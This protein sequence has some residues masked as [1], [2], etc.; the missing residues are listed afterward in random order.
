MDGPEC[1]SF[2]PS[3]TGSKTFEKKMS[4]HRNP[5]Y[6]YDAAATKILEDIPFSPP[7]LLTSVEH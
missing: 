4:G 5:A 6:V 1:V 3:G 2:V 7:P